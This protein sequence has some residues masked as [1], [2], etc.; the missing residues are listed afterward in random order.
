[1]RRTIFF[2]VVVWTTAIPQVLAQPRAGEAESRWLI[3]G[4]QVAGHQRYSQEQVVRSSAL[5]LGQRVSKRDLDETIAR[6]AQ[7][8]LFARIGYRYSIN[9]ARAGQLT[10]TLEVEEPEWIIPVVFDNFVWFTDQELTTAVQNDVPTFDGTLPMTLRAA[11]WMVRSLESILKLSDLAGRVVVRTHLRDAASAGEY[12]FSVENAVVPICAVALIGVRE[13]NVA[14]ALISLSAIKGTPYSRVSV[15][16]A[17][18]FAL[19]DVYR[20]RGYF[21]TVVG[22]PSHTLDS[23]C[24]GVSVAIPVVE[25]VQFRWGRIEWT[26]VSAARA[27]GLDRVLGLSNEGPADAAVLEARLRDVQQTLAAAGHIEAR[28]S[29]AFRRDPDAGRVHVTIQV[30]EG[31]VFRM[32]TIEFVNVPPSERALLARTWALRED[33]VY[34]GTYLSTFVRDHLSALSRRLPIT[35]FRPVVTIP[36][37]ST[38]VNIRIEVYR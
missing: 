21:D 13:E 34:D 22:V 27:D 6:M 9:K 16:A 14:A 10:L 38:V 26:G 19:R 24:Q 30:N 37:S 7:T 11:D 3:A 36:P 12:V 15:A 4:I 35:G 32:G 5:V 1:M 17:A 28:M 2:I 33:S 29:S 31:P 20:Q 23:S 25:G 8:G 18:Q